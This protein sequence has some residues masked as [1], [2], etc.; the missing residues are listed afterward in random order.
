MEYHYCQFLKKEKKVEILSDLHEASYQVCTRARITV[1]KLFTS[2]SVYS[3]TWTVTV[4]KSNFKLLKIIAETEWSKITFPHIKGFFE[5]SLGSFSGMKF[6]IYESLKLIQQEMQIGC[7]FKKTRHACQK[8][9]SLKNYLKNK[10]IL[11]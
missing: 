5:S 6:A 4:H 10:C 11:S 1:Q 3:A 8:N 7:F 2:C 9:L